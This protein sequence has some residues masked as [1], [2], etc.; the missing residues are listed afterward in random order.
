MALFIASSYPL[1]DGMQLSGAMLGKEQPPPRGWEHGMRSR[2]GTSQRGLRTGMERSGTMALPKVT[3]RNA[4][5]RGC[6]CLMGMAII[7][8]QAHS[9]HI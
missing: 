4:Q 3:C 2:C 1:R 9:I 8:S 6:V 7:V 5:A